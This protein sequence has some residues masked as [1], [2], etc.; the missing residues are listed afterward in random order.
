MQLYKSIFQILSVHKC[1]SSKVY[2]ILHIVGNYIHY[3]PNH[4]DGQQ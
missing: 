4:V 1:F 2:N 3:N